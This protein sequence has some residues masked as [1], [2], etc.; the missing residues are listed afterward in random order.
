MYVKPNSVPILEK[1]KLID[2]VDGVVDFWNWVMHWIWNLKV[3]PGLRLDETVDDAP[4]LYVDLKNA[5]TAGEGID[6]QPAANGGIIISTVY[7]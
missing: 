5:I 4:K 6:I 7:A 2:T 3:G 1:D